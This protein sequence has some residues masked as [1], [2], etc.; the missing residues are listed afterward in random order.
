LQA[1]AVPSFQSR[2]R[3]A[4]RLIVA[5]AALA[6]SVG[7][8]RSESPA[9]SK[10][11]KVW[12]TDSLAKVQPDAQPGSL[13]SVKMSAARNEFQSF[14][15]HVFSGASPIQLSLTVGDFHGPDGAVIRSSSNVIVYREAY[16]DITTLS[17]ANGALGVT[18]DPLI[19]AV[20]PYF[21]QVR[22]AF[23]VTVPANQTQSVW[24]D[25]LAPA[26]A[27]P[28]VYAASAT[29][30][31]GAKTIAT[32]PV[33]LTVWAF[34]LPSTATLK[35]AFG[36]SWDGLCVQAYGGYD[37]CGEYPGSGGDPD[38]AIE[39]MK[40]AE[41][42]LLLDHRVSVSQAVYVGPPSISWSQFNSIYGPLLDG[43]AATLL[44]GAKLTTLQF[45]PPGADDLDASTIQDWVANFSS[46]GWLNQLFHYTCDEPPNGCSW[47]DALA[48][49]EI[50]QGASTSMKT[51]ITTD[52]ALATQYDLLAD[53]NI[54]TPNVA[55]MEPQGGT[56]QRS[57][58]DG[59][60][61]GPNTH[62]WWYQSCTEHG[63]CSNGAVGPS[64]ATWPSYMVD[65]TPVRNRVFQWLAFLDQIEAE[66]YYQLDYCWVAAACGA[67][68]NASAPWTS[69]YAFGGNGDGTLI[70]PGTPAMIGGT[71]PIA[72]PSIRLK[73]IRDGM[74]DFE[75]LTA[76]SQAG[77]DAFA[78]SV[79]ATFI[80][81]AYTFNND[82]TAL[83]TARDMLASKLELLA[84]QGRCCLEP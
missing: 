9:A 74:Q 44:S 49:E 19:P 15:V 63:S 11:P 52:I 70:Y 17:D 22:N 4:T 24:I 21:H 38:D 36:L 81:N 34:T 68:S 66:L 47:A 14:Q 35:S 83:Q 58:Y 6:V 27:R 8:A 13:K 31:D 33:S 77:E 5:F 59:W 69:V 80:T 29:V 23:P 12:T 25:V 39:L 18:P 10:G 78:R 76:L 16:L 30:K 56:N 20:D 60:L 7:V 62:L 55:L 48:D 82:P 72:L 1:A 28:G 71:T 37:N 32:V 45:M 51:M 43:A 65:A 46:S 79:A 75:Y 64:S 61:G 84:R 53:L 73:Q 54:I 67:A 26:K 42:T 40:V 57:T 41:A 2:R 3:A 50:V